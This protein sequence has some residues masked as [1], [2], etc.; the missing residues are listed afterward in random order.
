MT[1]WSFL[2]YILYFV[3]VFLKLP[4]WHFSDVITSTF[5]ILGWSWRCLC[6]HRHWMTVYVRACMRP[7]AFRPISTTYIQTYVVILLFLAL[8]YF[9]PYIVPFIIHELCS[10]RNCTFLSIFI[11]SPQ[12]GDILLYHFHLSPCCILSCLLLS[13]IRLFLLLYTSWTQFLPDFT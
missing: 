11:L 7:H 13:L 5:N 6:V 12:W 9:C 1:G 3:T 2:P 10:R 8:A 4:T